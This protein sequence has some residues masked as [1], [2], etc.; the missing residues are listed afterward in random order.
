MALRVGHR[1]EV[2]TT[3]GDLKVK[4][5]EAKEENRSGGVNQ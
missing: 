5:K 2:R 4:C 3:I 1:D